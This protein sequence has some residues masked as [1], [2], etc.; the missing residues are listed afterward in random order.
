MSEQIAAA[1]LERLLILTCKHGLIGAWSAD[2][3]ERKE[4]EERLAL[5]AWALSMIEA[6]LVATESSPMGGGNSTV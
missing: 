3:S 6:G 1:A 2:E 5:H 4:Q